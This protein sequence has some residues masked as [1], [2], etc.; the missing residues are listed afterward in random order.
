MS[1]KATYLRFFFIAILVIHWFSQ[2]NIT[3]AEIGQWTSLGP[4]GGSVCSV[5]IDPS[6]PSTI[7][8]G[9]LGGGV[10]K[11]ADGGATWRPINN[12][13][14]NLSI[15]ALAIDPGTHHTLYAGTG[16]G[17]FKSLDGGMTWASTATDFYVWTFVVDPVTPTIVYA[18]SDRGVIKSVNGGAT[19]NTVNDGLP[20]QWSLPPSVSTLVIDPAEPTTLYAGTDEGVFKSVN[21]GASW[22]VAGLTNLTANTLFLVIDPTNSTTLYAGTYGNGVF[23]STTGGLSWAALSPLENPYVSFLAIDPSAPTTLYAIVD[24]KP[25]LYKTTDGGA[26]WTIS[27]NGLP[28]ST[29]SSRIRPYRIAIDP[30]NSTTLY[31]GVLVADGGQYGIG[32]HK[33]TNGGETWS[34]INVGLNNTSVSA[35]ALDSHTTT[36]LYAGSHCGVLK[37]INGDSNWSG[38]ANNEWGF[39]G[40]QMLVL[41]PVVSTT[42][43]MGRWS[44]SQ[45]PTSAPNG[46][47]KSLDGGAT[48][49]TLTS[50]STVV[51]DLV[52]DPT[53]T[54]TL[55]LATA[56]GIVKSLDGGLTWTAANTGLRA[57]YTFTLG[58]DPLTPTTL[59]A[60][61]FD[62]ESIWGGGDWRITGQVFKSTDGAN[63]WILV[64]TAAPAINLSVYPEGKR[65]AID[66][67]A[68]GTVFAAV[69]AEVVKTLDGGTTWS[70]VNPGLV[71][72]PEVPSLVIDPLIPSTLYAVTDSGVLKTTNGGTSWCPDLTTLRSLT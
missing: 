3:D 32:M 50:T 20:T 26:N 46:L 6:D 53:N 10:F 33:S 15:T 5:A 40:S 36:T 42:V 60:V 30:T 14:T 52:I 47:F 68:P 62:R 56:S 16:S 29:Y 31:V 12:G 22:S 49:V 65:L 4:D 43:Y 21:G 34:A 54:T 64:Y 63:N 17:I 59:Y 72:Y 70:K 44:D 58:I 39:C 55:Y 8:A 66:P 38:D 2:P 25:A 11:S 48:W 23:K 61:S 45:G 67:V 35:L 1:H 71:G 13:L 69:G 18:A 9:T 51:F 41:D 57:G 7:Y 28:A 27:D 24:G 37:S 19:W